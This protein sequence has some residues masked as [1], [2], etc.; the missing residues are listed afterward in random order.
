[1]PLLSFDEVN[2]WIFFKSQLIHTFT[3]SKDSNCCILYVDEKSSS[4]AASVNT[5]TKCGRTVC[6]QNKDLPEH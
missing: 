6:A 2:V 3:E 4:F 1:L 5:K